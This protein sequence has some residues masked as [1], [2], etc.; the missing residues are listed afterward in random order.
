MKKALIIIV[1]IIVVIVLVAGYFGF[2]PGVSQAMGANKAKDLGV[3]YT[4]EDL[5][6]A[7]QLAN[8]DL[9]DLSEGNTSLGFSGQQEITGDYTSEMITAMISSAKYKYY[10]LSNTQ[11]KINNDGTVEAAGNVNIAKLVKW[12]NDLGADKNVT[13]QASSY[14]GT[15]SANPSFYLKGKMDVANNQ[16]NLNLSQAKISR[17]SAP[18]SMINQY[19]GQLADFVEQRIAR[20]P[21]MDIKSAAFTDGKLKIDGTYPAIEKSTK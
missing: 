17:F 5:D 11:V 1:S 4:Q 12:S 20:V 18:S 3:K 7:R 13:D 10:P 2:V 8:I 19:Q 21:G 6:K 15:I 16:I 14:V 9:Q